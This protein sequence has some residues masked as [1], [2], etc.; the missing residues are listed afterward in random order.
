MPIQTFSCIIVDDES[1]SVRLLKEYVNNS[2]QLV[3][4]QTF[5]DPQLAMDYIFDNHQVDIL[6]SDLQMP[7]LSGIELAEAVQQKVKHIVFVTSSLKLQ[8]QAPNIPK[9]HYL[10]KPASFEDFRKMLHVLVNDK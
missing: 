5:T 1:F 3:L 9:W 10:G 2:E 4:M 7:N 6:F 8:I